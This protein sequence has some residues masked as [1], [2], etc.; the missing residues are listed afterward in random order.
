MILRALSKMGE[1]AT[2]INEVKRR[3][4]L[5]KRYTLEQ[6]G[7]GQGTL[8]KVRAH[9]SGCR[10]SGTCCEVSVILDQT[11]VCGSDWIGVMS[12]GESHMPTHSGL[13]LPVVAGVMAQLGEENEPAEPTVSQQ[14]CSRARAAR[15]DGLVR[16]LGAD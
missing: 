9:S 2:E 13:V 15:H 14:G 3:R 8:E 1:V 6:R 12:L 5:L 16:A 7:E 11:V 10:G 4:E